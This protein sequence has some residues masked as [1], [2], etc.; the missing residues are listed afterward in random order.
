LPKFGK[1][2]RQTGEFMDLEPGFDI[3]LGS[4]HGMR[5][6][7]GDNRNLAE[8]EKGMTALLIWSSDAYAS[9]DFIRVIS[10]YLV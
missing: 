5:N 2:M 6:E 10:Q 4:A 9:E 1:D 3:Y 7:P 8:P